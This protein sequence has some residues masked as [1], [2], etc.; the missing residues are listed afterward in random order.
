MIAEITKFN[1]S[2]FGFDIDFEFYYNQEDTDA[3]EERK[4]SIDKLYDFN[5]KCEG[6]ESVDKK[7][8][9]E[10]CDRWPSLDCEFSIRGAYPT[11][12]INKFIKSFSELFEIYDPIS[13]LFGKG[14]NKI[15][16]LEDIYDI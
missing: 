6:V 2:P 4:E 13:S 1:I 9:V 12:T 7:I 14:R 8:I 3:L 15:E 11:K 16:S 5:F 10:D